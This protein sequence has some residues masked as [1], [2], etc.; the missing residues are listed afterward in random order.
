[1]QMSIIRAE[2][3]MEEFHIDQP[4]KFK[5]VI[6]DKE[7]FKNPDLANIASIEIMSLEKLKKMNE[8]AEKNRDS[9]KGW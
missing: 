6:S 9:G 1:M 3:G 8:N 5:P 2:R 7:I 4:Q